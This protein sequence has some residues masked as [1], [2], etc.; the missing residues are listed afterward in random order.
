MNSSN[1][2]RKFMRLGNVGL[3][4]FFILIGLALLF[5]PEISGTAIVW[6][7]A[8]LLILF[9]IISIVTYFVDERY[10]VMR[11]GSF[12]T[13]LAATALGLLLAIRPTILIAFLPTVWGCLLCFG[14]FFKLQ[15]AIDLKRMSYK[16]WYIELIMGIVTVILGGVVLSDP[17]EAALV[18]T[19]FIGASLLIEG[20]S[21]VVATVTLNRVTHLYY[22]DR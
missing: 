14:G 15:A 17:F 11:R 9:G 22:P 21:D 13:G 5:A 10:A 4:A 6:A 12:T 7:L 18:M 2:L 19:R 16:R 20:I 3:S 8:T 1:G